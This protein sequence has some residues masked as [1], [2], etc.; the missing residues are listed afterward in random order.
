MAAHIS[1]GRQYIG[2]ALARYNRSDDPH[3]SRAGDVRDNVVK[4]QVHLH[5]SLLHV[6][7]MGSGVFNEPLSLTQIG[8]QGC[9]LSI[10]TEAPAYQTIGMKLAEPCGIAYIC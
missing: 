1:V 9:D 5:Q 6:L 7:D 10:R 8:A 3:A 2:I 4:L